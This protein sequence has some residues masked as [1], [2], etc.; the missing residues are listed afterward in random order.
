MVLEKLAQRFK[1][2]RRSDGGGWDAWDCGVPVHTHEALAEAVWQLLGW[3]QRQHRRF[4]CLWRVWAWALFD[5][6]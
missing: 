4:I 6:F 3:G 5:G 1:E 2:A